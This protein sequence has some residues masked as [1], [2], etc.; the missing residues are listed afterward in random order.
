[1]QGFLDWGIV[2]V[3]WLQQFSPAGDTFFKA[4]SFLGDET[5]FM[6]LLPLV[7]WCLDKRVGIRVT[8]LFLLSVFLGSAAKLLGNQPRP[9]AY[10]SRV[11]KLEDI[12]TPGFPSL[13][14]QNTTVIWSYLASQFQR[15]WLWA[16]TAVLMIL[17]P[18]SRL[19][20]GVHFPTDLLGGYVFGGLLVGL[21]LWKG[22]SL[23]LWLG[24]WGAMGWILLSVVSPLVALV[25]LSSA[26]DESVVT[27]AALLVSMGCGFIAEQRWVGFKTEG[28][29]GELVAR[30][31][32]GLAGLFILRFGLSALFQDL[33]PVY[34]FRFIRYLVIGI[35]GAFGAP[36]AFVR[37][38][39]AR[40]SLKVSVA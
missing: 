14:T 10:D 34:L 8:V 29:V 7:Y 11:Q 3:L 13:H 31:I 38:G 32:L 15:R 22:E 16:L 9:F 5:F 26:I 1:M 37:L 40:S 33:E 30:L 25:I 4:A 17:V 35:W 12:H 21:F 2:I 39:W 27:G 28:K 6:L 36:W 19:Y 20:L 24:Q 18:L 23:G